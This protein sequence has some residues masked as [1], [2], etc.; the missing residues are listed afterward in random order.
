VVEGAGDDSGPP[1]GATPGEQPVPAVSRRATLGDLLVELKRRRVF[2]VMVG[3]GIFAFAVLQVA[4]PIMH[5]A[6]LPDWVLK[7]LLVALAVG[8]PVALLMAW[9]FDLTAQGVRRTPS[10]RE[11]GGIYFSRRRLSALLLAVGLVGALPGVAWYL[12]K[13]SAERGPGKAAGAVTPSIA[14]LPFADMSPQKDQEYFAD[15]VAEEI[16]NALAQ[17]EG[18]LV[19]GRTSSFSFKGQREDLRIIGGKLGVE[20]ILEGSVRKVGQRLRVTAQLVKAAD[21]YHLWSQVFDRDAADLFAVQEEIARAVV[22]AL[23]RRL[24]PGQ[25]HVPRAASRDAYDLVLQGRLGLREQSLDGARQALERFE[26][27]A[28]LDPAYAQAW[29]GV[30][31]AAAMLWGYADEPAPELATRAFTAAERAIALAPGQPDGYRTRGVIR[32]DRDRDWAGARADLERA[33]ALGPADPDAAAQLALLLSQ[34]GEQRAAVAEARRATTVDPLSPVAWGGL[35]LQLTMADDLPG[36]R[37]A[38]ERALALSRSSLFAVQTLLSN[39]VLAGQPAEALARAEGLE[40]GWLRSWATALALHGLGRP[41]ASAEALDT[42]ARRYGTVAAYQ[43]AEVH[44][45]RG[46]LDQAFEWLN[47]AVVQWDPGLCITRADPLLR[48]LHRDPRWPA[49]LRRLNLPVS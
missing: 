18:L 10:A 31:E 29:A 17:V 3:Y 44:A 46:E 28:A 20:T 42:L 19:V 40:E 12:W 26:R 15:G 41:Q 30:A 43:V 11:S 39:F 5:G 27:A 23:S 21:G 48:A 33:V 37:A 38:I 14:V 36:G 8:F 9:L 34:V 6:G 4:E 7:A 49:L 47:R 16:L 22:A 35:G 32:R 24:A 2:R 25:V 13:R 45:W 1:T